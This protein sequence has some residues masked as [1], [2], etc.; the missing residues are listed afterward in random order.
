MIWEESF[1]KLH[2]RLQSV[3]IGYNGLF[4]LL[5]VLSSALVVAIAVALTWQAAIHL[6][7]YEVHA[8]A[9]AWADHLQDHSSDL[10]Q[11][12][13][14]DALPDE[15]LQMP[16]SVRG[17]DAVFFYRLYDRSGRR[18]YQSEIPDERLP[19]IL[20][21]DDDHGTQAVQEA[22]H[23]DRPIVHLGKAEGGLRPAPSLYGRI[24]LPVESDN[25]STSPPKS[26]WTRPRRPSVTASRS[27]H[28]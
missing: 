15:S 20:T 24:I 21:E 10:A 7:R 12:L 3:S 16:Q 25:A 22:M 4:L 8:D 23:A 11:I 18:I 17:I 13:T 28:S 6:L 5:W 26:I 27:W 9:S 1:G 2:Q 14:S 19:F